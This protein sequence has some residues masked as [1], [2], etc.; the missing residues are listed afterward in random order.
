FILAHFDNEGTFLREEHLALA[1]RLPAEWEDSGW[2]R[3][4]I[5]PFMESEF[6]LQ[7]DLI[8]IHEF[9]ANGFAHLSVC[10]WPASR[11]NLFREPGG[12]SFGNNNER[13]EANELVHRW[14][15]HGDFEIQLAGGN[16]YWAGPD[17]RIHSS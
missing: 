16:D 14:L 12:L 4:K 8:H 1:G 13:R 2:K 5:G 10:Q 15:V 3:E 9:V 6:G 11:A 7:L 17:G